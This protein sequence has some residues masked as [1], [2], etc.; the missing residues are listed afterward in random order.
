MI[1][2]NADK[3]AKQLELQLQELGLKLDEASRQNNDLTSQKSRLLCGFL[4]K[5]THESPT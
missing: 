2:V 4:A 1:K 3:L 5:T